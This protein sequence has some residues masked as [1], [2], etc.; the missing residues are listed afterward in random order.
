MA[1]RAIHIWNPQID[2]ATGLFP[3]WHRLE[4]QLHCVINTEMDRVR[5]AHAR[6][7]ERIEIASSKLLRKEKMSVACATDIAELVNAATQCDDL[8]AGKKPTM[9]IPKVAKPS[10]FK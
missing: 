5:E 1:A 7:I 9:I 6:L 2:A 3:T 8:K 4:S 10:V